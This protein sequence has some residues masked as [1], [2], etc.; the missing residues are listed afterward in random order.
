MYNIVIFRIDNDF[1][2]LCIAKT[3]SAIYQF[4]NNIPLL[5][6][7]FLCLN[8]T[9]SDSWFQTFVGSNS[10]FISI[11]RLVAALSIFRLVAALSIFRL[12]AALFLV[13]RPNK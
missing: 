7:Y 9:L 8:R 2:L 3:F 12:V 1:G 10:M 5:F 6:L 4:F 13:K 11:F